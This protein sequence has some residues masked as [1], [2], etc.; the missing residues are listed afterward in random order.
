VVKLWEIQAESIF[1]MKLTGILPLIPLT[2]NGKQPNF[3]QA[4][5][6]RLAEKKE[7]DLLT[8]ASIVGSLV[9]KEEDERAWFKRRF[10]MFQDIL[11]DS[12]VYQQ[13]GEDFFKDGIKQE[14]Q[15]ELRRFRQMVAEVAQMRFSSLLTLAEQKAEVI[16]DPDALQQ[17]TIQLIG[18]RDTDEARELLLRV[19]KLEEQN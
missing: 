5:I 10:I 9:F 12:W 16:E 3:V 13:I 4:M 14:R 1:Q 19:S 18:A 6:D 15:Q 2:E 7:M 11:R 8:I 17:L